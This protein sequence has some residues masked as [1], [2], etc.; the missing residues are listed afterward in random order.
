MYLKFINYT[1][2]EYIL[3]MWYNIKIFEIKKKNNNN[4]NNN[5]IQR[6]N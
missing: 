1:N 6:I 3:Y 5:N 2:F 4:N